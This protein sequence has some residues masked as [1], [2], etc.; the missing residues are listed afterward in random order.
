[1]RNI[2]KT[3]YNCIPFKQAAF[4][5]LRKVW[6]PSENIYKHL[7]FKGIII[8]P[9]DKYGSFKIKHYGYEVENSIFWQG[10]TGNWEKQSL[11]LWIKL[12]ADAE[13]VLDIGANTGVYALIAKTVRPDAKVYAFEPVKR[14]YQ[15][16]QENIRLNNYDITPTEKAVSNADGKAVIYDPLTE[17]TYSVTVNSNLYKSSEKVTATEID[18]LKLDTFIAENNIS[19]VDLIKIDVET[20]EPEVL[21]GFAHYLKEF[22]P[23]MLVEIIK[24]D[25]GARIKELLNGLDY[26]YFYIDEEKG[27]RQVNELVESNDRNYLLC[28]SE[29]A[30]A[31]GL[32]R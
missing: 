22:K 26:I 6:K 11:G 16:L 32:I 23:V 29:K 19:K 17:H 31:L 24:T 4:T 30:R 2:I 1:M 18:T 21:E 8:V 7:H 20:H 10:L 3:I 9:V 14:V 28:T 5:A 27:I 13:V 12:C 25:I 15:K